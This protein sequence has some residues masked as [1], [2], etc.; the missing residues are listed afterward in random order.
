MST[1]RMSK[2]NEAAG[3][4]NNGMRKENKMKIQRKQCDTRELRL[5]AAVKGKG[6]LITGQEWE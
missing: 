2:L 5:G 6:Y 1:Q 4:Q 3:N